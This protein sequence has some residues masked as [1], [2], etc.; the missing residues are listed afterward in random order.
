M[1]VNKQGIWILI[2]NRIQFNAVSPGLVSSSE[3][4][5]TVKR[6][7]EPNSPFL[8]ARLGYHFGHNGP[9]TRCFYVYRA[10]RFSYNAVLKPSPL[11]IRY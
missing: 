3:L 10:L 2:G 1:D 7:N 6:H 9:I 11:V 8:Q 5:L 4:K